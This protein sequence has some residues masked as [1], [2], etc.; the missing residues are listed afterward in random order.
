MIKEESLLM[1]WNKTSFNNCLSPA[2]IVFSMVHF[3]LNMAII[4][5]VLY[6]LIFQA[7]GLDERFN[8]TLQNMLIKYVRNKQDQ[9]DEFLDTCTFAYNTSVQ[10]LTHYSPFELM[11]GRKATMPIDL[12]MDK[13]NAD[14]KMKNLLEKGE[15]LTAS[16]LEKLTNK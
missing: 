11:F 8:Q 15:G 7:I 16:E 10:E 3:P 1:P 9:W 4:I 6:N 13:H 14:G 5:M 2:G 12:D